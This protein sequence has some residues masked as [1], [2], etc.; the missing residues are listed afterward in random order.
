MF[1]NSSSR[2][3]QIDLSLIAAAPTHSPDQAMVNQ[4]F[5]QNSLT[6]VAPKPRHTR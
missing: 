5:F 6:G 1:P 2:S 4:K 3:C